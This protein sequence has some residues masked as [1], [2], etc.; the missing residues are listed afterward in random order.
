M[1]AQIAQGAE[2]LNV[3]DILSKTDRLDDDSAAPIRYSGSGFGG[4]GAAGSARLGLG[5]GQRSLTR[6][7]VPGI[8]ADTAAPFRGNRVAWAVLTLAW[9]VGHL[10]WPVSEK[11]LAIWGAERRGPGAK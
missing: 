5:L 8:A 11:I 9:H 7:L 2:L 3:V 4:R 10:R 1:I 6:L